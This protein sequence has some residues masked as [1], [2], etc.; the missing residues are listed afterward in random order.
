VPKRTKSLELG[1]LSVHGGEQSGQR[2]VDAPVVHPLF[3]SV[4]YIQEIASSADLRYPRHGNAP[5]AEVVQRRIAAIEHAEASLLLASGMGAT[6]CALLALVRPG[7]HIIASSWIYGGTRELLEQEFE[8]LGIKVSLVDPLE[9]RVWRKAIKKNTRVIFVESPVNPTCRVLDMESLSMVTRQAGIALVVDATF[10]SPVNFRP[11]EHGAD[12]SIHSATKYLNGH[13]D[14]LG[15]VV[16]GTAPYIDEVRR[17]MMLWGQAPDP[18]A[19]WLLER[20]L[21]TLELRVLRQNESAMRIA[22]WCE[23]RKEI[24]KVMYPGLASHPDHEIAD[25]MLDGFGGMLSIELSGGAKPTER[26]LRRLKLFRHAPSL[27]GVESLVSEPR[28]TSHAGISADDRA[29]IGIPDGFVRVSVGI[30]GADDLI[31]D[32]EQALR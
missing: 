12:V 22:R 16:S 15:G 10:A 1:T 9:T 23:D 29:E 26:F 3:Q 4:N 19:A 28:F 21:K 24:R 32:L 13:H 6:A 30:E 17:K 7:D 14:V 27:G 25:R 2:D 18:F 5:N 8:T 20:G 11:L 31:A